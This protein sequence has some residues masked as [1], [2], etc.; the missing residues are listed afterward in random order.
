MAFSALSAILHFWIYNQSKMQLVKFVGVK[1]QASD[2]K[3]ENILSTGTPGPLKN[4]TLRRLDTLSLFCVKHCFSSLEQHVASS[5][6][7]LCHLSIFVIKCVTVVF[8]FLVKV[9]KIYQ[10]KCYNVVPLIWLFM[11]Y[12]KNSL[13]CDLYVQLQMFQ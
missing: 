13:L 5:Q 7:G 4:G 12:L 6:L 1:P 9:V 10:L 2:G 8:H 11:T 3:L